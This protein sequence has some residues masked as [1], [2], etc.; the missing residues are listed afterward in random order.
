MEVTLLATLQEL[1]A[2]L[3][4]TPVS[5][6]LLEAITS[7]ADPRQ[8]TVAIH[9]MI[10]LYPFATFRVVDQEI[11]VLGEAESLEGFVNQCRQFTPRVIRRE[12]RTTVHLAVYLSADN[13]FEDAE[14]AVT[15][16]VSDIGCFVYSIR[17][18][19]IGHRVWLRLLG[20]DVAIP[21]TVCSWQP[22][23]NNKLLPGVG[24]ELDADKV[25]FKWGL[26]LESNSLS[27]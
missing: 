13:T 4:T 18:W 25:P 24:I 10:D 26:E 14:R 21:G 16:N 7:V 17:N 12:I 23:G 15:I 22:W 3:K 6:I 27:D 19:T 5:G 11:L 8:D 1:P 20:D 9:E 2:V